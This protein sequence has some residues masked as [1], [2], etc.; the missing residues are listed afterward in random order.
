MQAVCWAERWQCDELGV[1]Q[2][3]MDTCRPR[4]PQQLEPSMSPRH[5]GTPPK[6]CSSG[7]AGPHNTTIRPNTLLALPQH[8]PAGA[9]RSFVTFI[10]EPLYKL[11]ATVVGEHPKTIERVLGEEFGVFL[12]SSS[13]SQDVKPLLKEVSVCVFWGSCV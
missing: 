4:A 9:E 8:S 5:F 11:T 10:L 12:K 6:G 13:Y 2:A 7:H 3:C 1:T